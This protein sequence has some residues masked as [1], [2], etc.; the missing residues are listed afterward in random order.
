MDAFSALSANLVQTTPA[1]PAT[2]SS[3]SQ[4]SNE[5]FATHLQSA[6]KQQNAGQRTDIAKTRGKAQGQQQTPAEQAADTPAGQ[7]AASQPEHLTGGPEPA[8][9]DKNGAPADPTTASATL[10]APSPP[11]LPTQ[12]L[13]TETSGQ[14][15][16]GAQSSAVA[17]MLDALAVP[18][19]VVSTGAAG[20]QR[21]A[22]AAATTPAAAISQAG[23]VPPATDIPSAADVPSARVVAEAGIQQIVVESVA[24]SPIPPAASPSTTASTATMTTPASPSLPSAIV[25][26]T[27][28]GTQGMSGGINGEI[29]PPPP[30]PEPGAPLVV[31]NQ[32][33]QII[34]IQHNA[35]LAAAAESQGNSSPA[36][37]PSSSDTGTDMDLTNQYIHSHL[38]NETAAKGENAS[39]RSGTNN[40]SGQSTPNNQTPQAAEPQTSGDPLLT[41]KGLPPTGQESQPLI[42]SHQQG[43]GLTSAPLT[44]STSTAAPDSSLYRLASGA[45]VPEGTVIDQMITHF[46]INKHLESGTV[47][48]KLHPQELGELHMEIK[49]E[50]D[51]VKAHIVTQSAH[52]QEMIDRHLP[53]LREAL[54]QQGLHL[55]QV[56][57]TVA[58]NDNAAGERFQEQTTGQQNHRSM[59]HKQSQSPFALDL[60]EELAIN[61]AEVD[62]NL[63]VIA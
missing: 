58:S 21:P 28:T 49:V 43:S 10:V 37:P 17:R 38:P 51:N 5:R 31:Q 48:L 54:A 47:N 30:A 20:G 12:P 57:V 39:N 35:A 27:A 24:N 60:D 55:G 45:T 6:T 3:S 29:P 56:E 32:Y 53:K 15:T 26:Q 36:A 11:P 16:A 4:S 13:Q 7:Q 42:F 9:I 23:A 41:V 33:G 44:T 1:P 62:N 50:Q 14:P 22:P 40:D 25:L 59:G 46:S 34:T 19:P 52:A 8:E 18:A 2:A 61:T 63:S